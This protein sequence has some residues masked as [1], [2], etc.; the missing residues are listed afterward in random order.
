MDYHKKFNHPNILPIIGAEIKGQADIVHN[1]V[2]EAYLVLPYFPR[3]TLADALSKRELHNDPFQEHMALVLFLQICEG[4]QHIHQAEDIG[5]P[6]AHRDLKP[7]NIL[8]REDY[9]PVIMDLGS[10][11]PS[12]VTISTHSQAQYL[13]DLCAE[14]CSM[15]YRSPE[16]F[17]VDSKCSIDERTDVWVRKN[18]HFSEFIYQTSYNFSHWDVYYMQLHFTNHHLT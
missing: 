16:L 14:R 7:H 2:S 17:Q 6:F 15:P 18:C 3:G 10:V 4:V 9:T 13:Q 5:G 11:E 8:L 12:R 1:I